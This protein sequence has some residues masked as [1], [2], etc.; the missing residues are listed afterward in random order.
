M[1]RG[2]CTE[3]AT[4]RDTFLPIVTGYGKPAWV[5]EGGALPLVRDQFERVSLVPHT[6]AATI[7]VTRELLKD[8]A[9]DIEKYLADTFAQRLTEAEEEAFTPATASQSL[10]VLSN[11]SSWL[12][13]ADGG[14]DCAG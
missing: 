5:T 13:G 8:S 2:L 11:S 10:R 3:I 7:R 4:E 9:V 12:R 6:L 1:L 14:Y